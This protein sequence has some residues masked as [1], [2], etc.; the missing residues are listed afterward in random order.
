MGLIHS[1]SKMDGVKSTGTL[2]NEVRYLV[3]VQHA[4]QKTV[5]FCRPNWFLS[6]I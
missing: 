4:V 3:L 2:H 1:I 6:V 5:L